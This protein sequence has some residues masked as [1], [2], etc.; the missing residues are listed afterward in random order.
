MWNLWED[1]FLPKFGNDRHRL[2][3]L[4][5]VLEKLGAAARVI[6]DSTAARKAPALEDEPAEPGECGHRHSSRS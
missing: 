1:G 3:D 5:H 6:G 2:V 4:H